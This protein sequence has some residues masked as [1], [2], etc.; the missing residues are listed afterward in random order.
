MAMI[1]FSIPMPNNPAMAMAKTI[2]GNACID[3]INLDTT[4]STAPPK[5]PD[6]TPIKVPAENTITVINTAENTDV[7]APYKT[8]ES[9]HLPR[10]SFPKGYW[11]L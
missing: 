1:V 11:A 7:L 2:F 9:I 3:V 6:T 8:L 5:Y 10:W 4:A